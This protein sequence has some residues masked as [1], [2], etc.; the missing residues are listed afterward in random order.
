MGIFENWIIQTIFTIEEMKV[1]LNPHLM[2][3]EGGLARSPLM[4]VHSEQLQ[5]ARD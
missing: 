2:S 1:P 4:P 3:E 5:N